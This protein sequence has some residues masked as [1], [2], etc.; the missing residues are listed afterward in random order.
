MKPPLSFEF[1]EAFVIAGGRSTA[2]R[3]RGRV[4]QDAD[5]THEFL[6]HHRRPGLCG[7]ELALEIGD[8]CLGLLLV[9]IQRF[10]RF[11]NL[12]VSSGDECLVRLDG[13][14]QL[15]DFGL[16]FTHTLIGSLTLRRKIPV[17]LI[18]PALEVFSAFVRDFDGL[19]Q[20]TDASA[21]GGESRLGRF[22]LGGEFACGSEVDTEAGD[23]LLGLLLT[24][25]GNVAQGVVALVEE[26]MRDSS[27][28]ELFLRS[29]GLGGS[30]FFL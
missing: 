23:A 30:G 27:F 20:R 1:G 8:A 11:R 16:K 3:W 13:L 19:L 10:G 29:S 6:L 18:E 25:L 26:L 14:I 9:G 7:G 5:S 21:L 24:A 22:E 17:G 28:V 2:L 15:R 12:A 4:W